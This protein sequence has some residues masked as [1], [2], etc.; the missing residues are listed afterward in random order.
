M[1]DNNQ[2]EILQVKLATNQLPVYSVN[3]AT[4]IIEQGKNNDYSE[5][6]LFLLNNHAEH[7]A[8]VRGKASYVS[9]LSI[10]PK[11]DNATVQAFLDRAN[12][13]ESWYDLL[14]KTDLDDANF[15]GHYLKIVTNAVGAPVEWHHIDYAKVRLKKDFQTFEL[16]ED[17]GK[18]KYRTNES[19]C[20]PKYVPGTVGE[21]I[22]YLKRYTPSASKLQ[23]AYAQPEFM[24]CTLDI[25]TDIR[26]GSFFNNYVKNNWSAGTL[27][28]IFNG[29]TDPVKKKNI[30]ERVNNEYT[31]EDN[32][33]KILVEFV[34][35]DG[36]GAE[37]LSLNANDLD[38]QYAEV[39][40]RN[41][42]KIVAGHG[43]NGPLFKI[44]IDDKAMLS[45]E[46]LDLQ[47]ELFIN[48]YAKVRQVT[49]LN[50]LSKWCK[51]ATG[52]EVEFEIE[53]VQLI[54][55]E[56]PLDN[57]NVIDALNTINPKIFTEYIINKFGLKVPE[58]LDANGV[59]V[60]LPVEES[61]KVNEV[62]KGL[63]AKEHMDMN[64]IVRDF[65]KDR[66][67]E[68]LAMARIRNYGIDDATAKEI[69]GIDD[70]TVVQQ[71]SQEKNKRIEELF[72]KYSHEIE[73]SEVLEVIPYKAV[74]LAEDTT[75]NQLRNGILDAL[76]GNPFLTDEELAK[77]L[78]VT[79]VVIGTALTWLI[80]KQLIEPGEGSYQPTEKAIAKETEPVETE[81][82]TEYT[83]EKR[84]DVDGPILLATSRPNCIKWVNMTRKRAI[85]YEAIQKLTN[86]FGDSAYD[87]R[88]GFYNDNGEITPWCRHYWEGHTKIRR[89]K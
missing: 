27:V 56:L 64:R 25:D 23:S 83:Y 9:G 35:K 30:T 69:L 43:V 82:V 15:G 79:T 62:L 12:P 21:S 32:A 41:K 85:T 20:Y 65:A 53:Q 70:A 3:S 5:Y 18:N 81:I 80:T 6:L 59:P 38:K 22:C 29:Q 40:K 67:N 36:K 50:R 88:G 78:N 1:P 77:L 39:S 37:V 75:T 61:G 11:E 76:K 87:F 24:S 60:V 19:T 52:Q 4:G 14:L 34:A 47:H 66:L 89:K 63:T 2:L 86:E 72:L 42:E 44:K 73:D 33:G 84:P 45:R 13:T 28:T 54:G 10:K 31:G 46:E 16:R 71:A 51:I 49:K 26:V 7:G 8:I 57:Q 55:L 17:W 48:E 58:T 68:V 74:R